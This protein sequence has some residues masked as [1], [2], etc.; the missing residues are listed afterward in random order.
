MK[1]L[2]KLIIRNYNGGPGVNVHYDNKKL[3]GKIFTT[4]GPHT[5]ELWIDNFKTP[6]SLVI[7]MFNKN[8][9]Y[10]TLLDGKKNIIDDKACY[11]TE[12]CFGDISLTDELFLFNFIRNNGIVISNNVYMGFNGKFVID[13]ND[14]NI[15]RWYDGLQKYLITNSEQYDYEKFKTEIFGVNKD[16]FVVKY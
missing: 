3:F 11:I 13:I 10:D 4:A 9:K 8:M 15:H 5:I 6:G 12:V 14:N 2:I 1:I 7:E 16:N